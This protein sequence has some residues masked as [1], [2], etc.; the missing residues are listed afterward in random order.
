MR[1]RSAYWSSTRASLP[2]RERIR[3][4]TL[5]QEVVHNPLW[6]AVDMWR[7]QLSAFSLQP[8]AFSEESREQPT[9]VGKVGQLNPLNERLHERTF[10]C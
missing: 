9:R 6:I 1:P 7:S 3:T 4:P 2:E 8:S 5:P 10:G